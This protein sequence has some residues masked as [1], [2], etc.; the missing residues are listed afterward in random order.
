LAA[1]QEPTPQDDHL[2]QRQA[3]PARI[4]CA[5]SGI[6][7]LAWLWAVGLA[8]TY[9]AQSIFLASFGP[10]RE[11][12]AA[13]GTAAGYGLLLFV[14][15]G[16]LAFF[17]RSE[18]YRSILRAW[19]GAA[20]FALVAAP[21]HLALPYSVQLR[22]VLHIPA[23]MIF[24]LLVWLLAGLPRVRIPNSRT[25][26]SLLLP[27]LPAV[28]FTYPWLAFGA[29]G[30]PLDTLSHLLA[31]L[32]CGVALAFLLEVTI[33]PWLSESSPGEKGLAS[34]F[35]GFFLAGVA[36]ATTILV[37][38]SGMGFGYFGMQLLLM[39]ALPVLGFAAAAVAR[40]YSQYPSPESIQMVRFT[41]VALMISLGAAAPMTLISPRDLYL[42]I[43][44]GPGEIWS[45]S[46][47]AAILSALAGAVVSLTIFIVLNR[48][49]QTPAL[50]TED[51]AYPSR[52][53]SPTA[54]TR[55]LFILLAAVLSG[56]LLF[57][58]PS[59]RAGFHSDTLFVIMSEQADLSVP[60][61]EGSP[62]ERRQ[63]V[64][65]LLTTH[66]ESS[67]ADL[68]SVLDRWNI[69]FTPFYIV[70]GIEVQ[71]GPL[72][73]AWLNTRSDV[74]R[75]LLNPWM[76]PLPG[77]R[78]TAQGTSRT[79]P[80]D[81]WNLQ[82]VQ[83]ERVWQEFGVT[84]AGIVIG[85]SDSGVDWQHPELAGSYRG[86]RNG[87]QPD[88]DYNWYDPWYHEPIPVDF[89]GHGTHTL[90]T[91][92]GEAV[93]VAPGAAWF[94]CSNLSRNMGNPALYLGCMQ[95]MLAPFPVGG[96]PFSQGSP[97][98]GAH[99]VNNSWGCPEVEGCDPTSL[100][101][102]IYA[103]RQAGIF[104]VVSAGND[105]PF[106]QSLNNP[107]AIYEQAFSVGAVD[108]DGNLTSFSSIGPVASDGRQRVKPDL[109]APG[110][111][112]VSAMPGGT[113]SPLSGTSMAGPHVS[114][115]VALMW[116][117]N[118]D[119]ISNIDR[120]EDLLIQ[121]AR[122]YTG[123]LPDCPGAAEIPSTAFGYGILDAYEAVRLALEEIR[124]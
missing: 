96:D 123:S 9:I 122:P 73:R 99:I 102:A 104:V 45:W 66:A 110:Q 40:I 29:L 85:Q 117:A 77:I 36:A 35:P 124:P 59:D 43:G 62:Q 115:V 74:D 41:G 5:G 58:L 30:S 69:A 14:P 1:I 55:G 107:P 24:I 19:S 38:A 86:L 75:V 11:Q 118:P 101:F 100:E 70:N 109:V 23:A 25:M 111:S 113:Y 46:A 67:Q 53:G 112:V 47:A 108:R 71:G 65:D 42:V 61:A 64:F 106:C 51:S 7:V 56:I 48:R 33:L 3:A 103:L 120:T 97:D 80:P 22:A 83:A 27:L 37:F 32:S 94:G 10:E 78:T 34:R 114:G 8:F 87:D 54:E 49:R 4:S 92:L 2:P 116:S 95:F 16:I 60:L 52:R 12:L 89:L 84:G 90:G 79:P 119:L 91:I 31:A 105:G 17:W 82:A 20:L 21:I 18:P 6:L 39:L 57:Y 15:L 93:G 121:S 72:L 68:R 98:L 63:Q 26:L 44:L 50:N 28:F 76:R 81:P 88:H 13:V